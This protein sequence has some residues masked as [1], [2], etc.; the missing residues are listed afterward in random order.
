M[1]RG[2]NDFTPA[3]QRFNNLAAIQS[4][5]FAATSV[6]TNTTPAIGKAAA[7]CCSTRL[8]DYWVFVSNT[9]FAAIEPPATL[10]VR[11]GTWNNHQT[12]FPNPSTTI[13]VNATGRYVRVQLSGTHYLSLAEV[14]VFGH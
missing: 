11:S 12:T 5:N 9:P 13:P 10:Q 2:R 7:H 1:T 3:S 6:I 4:A 8:S 14:Q